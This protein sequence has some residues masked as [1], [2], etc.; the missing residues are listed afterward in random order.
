VEE[1]KVGNFQTESSELESATGLHF[2]GPAWGTFSCGLALG[3]PCGTDGM[4][5]GVFAE[6][7]E[8]LLIGY[9]QEEASRLAFLGFVCSTRVL[10]EL[11]GSFPFP[12]SHGGLALGHGL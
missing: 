2:N 12:F 7:N 4:R 5:Q 6:I 3:K 9:I 1:E 11:L 8:A 10:G